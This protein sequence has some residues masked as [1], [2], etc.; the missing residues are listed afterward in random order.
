MQ[1]EKTVKHEQTLHIFNI[2][3]IFICLILLIEEL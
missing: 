2:R 1:N 3:M